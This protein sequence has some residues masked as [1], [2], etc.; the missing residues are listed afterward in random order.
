VESADA[1]TLA[2]LMDSRRE[3][4][5]QYANLAGERGS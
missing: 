5:V 3:A 4:V 2:D 1:A